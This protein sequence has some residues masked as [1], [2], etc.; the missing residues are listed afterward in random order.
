MKQLVVKMIAGLFACIFSVGSIQGQEN[1]TDYSALKK[2]NLAQ[3]AI[4]NFYVDQTDEHKLVESAIIGM[5]EELDPHSTYSNAEEVK[6]M[7]YAFR[8][9]EFHFVS[10]LFLL[11]SRMRQWGKFV[12]Q[13]LSASRITHL[14]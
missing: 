5:L 7:L 1:K 13:I 14:I 4:M 3:F 11:K 2:L 12:W 10:R 9:K 8:W 6:K